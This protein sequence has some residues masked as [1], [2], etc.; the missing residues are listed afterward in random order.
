MRRMQKRKLTVQ[1]MK[2]IKCRCKRVMDATAGR[3]WRWWWCFR[4][5]CKRWKQTRKRNKRE[6]WW[7]WWQKRMKIVISSSR[8]EGVIS[9]GHCFW[10]GSFSFGRSPIS[11]PHLF[12]LLLLLIFWA[13]IFCL[14]AFPPLLVREQS[15]GSDNDGV[16]IPF[17]ISSFQQ[18]IGRHN[19]CWRPKEE[20]ISFAKIGSFGVRKINW[21]FFDD[22]FKR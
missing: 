16:L 1:R 5:P 8:R 7:W 2:I 17:I 22:K 12:S 19:F 21:K 13:S 10:R 6:G 18:Q 20:S 4:T 14:L 15:F 9:V 3:W 11:S